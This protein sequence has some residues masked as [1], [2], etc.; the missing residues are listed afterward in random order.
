MEDLLI[1]LTHN[2]DRTFIA[3]ILFLIGIYLLI[4]RKPK[5]LV[6]TK[7]ITKYEQRIDTLIKNQQKITK[8]A[9]C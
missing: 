9:L 6:N 1:Y 4:H 5:V 3:G 7:Y 2:E 8:F